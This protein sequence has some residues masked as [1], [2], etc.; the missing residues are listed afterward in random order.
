MAGIT[1]K[2]KKRFEELCDKIANNQNVPINE[3]KSLQSE[4]KKRVL[5]DYN[6]FV[7][8]YFPHYTEREDGTHIDCAPFHLQAA[9]ELSNRKQINLFLEFYRGAA[10]SVHADIFFPFWLMIKNELKFMALFGENADKGKRL[11]SDLQAEFEANPLIIHDYGKQVNGGSW[12]EG[13]FYTK[14]GIYFK[15]GGLGQSPRGFRK[16]QHRPDYVVLDDFEERKTA[17]NPTLIKE[18]VNWVSGDVM[19]MF[20]GSYQR[21]VFAQNRAYKNGILDS[22]KR[23]LKDSEKTCIISVPAVLPNGEP[24]WKAKYT[25]EYWTQKQLDWTYRAFQREYM[26]NPITDG[27]IFKSDWIHYKTPL[28]FKEYEDI[29]GYW[30]L[31]YTSNGDYKAFVLVG[32]KLD[33]YHVLRSYCRKTET[34]HAI[35][36]YYDLVKELNEKGIYFRAYYEG[37]AQQKEIFAK[38]FNEEGYRRGWFTMPLADMASKANKHIRVESTLAAP[39][40]HKKIFFN[41]L[42]KES[43]DLIAGIDQLLAFEKGSKSHDDYPDTLEGAISKIQT[44]AI[45]NSAASSGFGIVRRRMIKGF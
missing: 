30:D 19:G 44:S 38:A 21:L 7:Q 20:D 16:K 33:E 23:E 31:S 41:I 13:D 9:N 43:P 6:F 4:R 42:E 1:D 45:T 5:T 15:S 27:G 39:L 3:S 37:L 28:D 36:W 14:S 18:M 29:V 26:N 8:T 34:T 12:E 24:T 10:K 11:L 2:D 25:K 17:K 35:G 32:K 22:L 40:Y